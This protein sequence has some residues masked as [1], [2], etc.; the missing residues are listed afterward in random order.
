M[1]L[2]IYLTVSCCMKLFS[3]NHIGHM[4]MFTLIYCLGLDN[5]SPIQLKDII[6]LGCC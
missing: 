3:D 1:K 6:R 2:G 5:I 4:E